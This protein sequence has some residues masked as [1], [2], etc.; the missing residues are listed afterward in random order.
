MSQT[1]KLL[2][3]ASK[4]G[5]S[6]KCFKCGMA[7]LQYG[8]FED[9]NTK[10]VLTTDGK[11]PNGL[12]GKESN[13]GFLYNPNTKE[14]H[15]CHGPTGLTKEYYKVKEIDVTDVASKKIYT[16]AIIHA[17]YFLIIKKAVKDTL[18]EESHPGEVSNLAIEIF[19][20]LDDGLVPKN[21]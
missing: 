17:K 3:S 16:A 5:K 18:G 1:A 9:P 11:E 14:I 2:R 10:K 6:Y 12:F 19:K 8:T 21:D 4:E 13:S 7:N 20:G 15:E